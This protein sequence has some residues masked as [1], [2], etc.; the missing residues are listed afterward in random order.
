MLDSDFSFPTKVESRATRAPSQLI[1]MRVAHKPADGP[2]YL[3]VRLGAG[4]F[5]RLTL[6]APGARLAVSFDVART[7]L[8]IAVAEGGWKP[9][10]TKKGNAAEIWVPLRLFT[11]PPLQNARGLAT[12]IQDANGV[13][14]VLELTK[15][16]AA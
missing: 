1:S 4:A 14:A 11:D 5:E 10:R 6:N 9:H 16:A 7:R 8:G 12:Y 13:I 15:G 2:P 3:V